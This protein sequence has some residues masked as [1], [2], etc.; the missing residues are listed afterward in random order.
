M[1]YNQ[2]EQ[3][4]DT[5]AEIR[6]RLAD[7]ELSIIA[8]ADN[9]KYTIEEHRARYKRALEDIQIELDKLKAEKF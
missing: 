9:D 2:S 6:A 5:I 1:S 4:I 3:I 7:A 8:I